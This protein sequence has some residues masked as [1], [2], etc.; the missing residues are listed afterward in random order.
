MLFVQKLNNIYEI[1]SKMLIIKYLLLY[2][3]IRPRI[4]RFNV[5][6]NFL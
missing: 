6:H 4:L 2:V 1:F 5:I 3:G